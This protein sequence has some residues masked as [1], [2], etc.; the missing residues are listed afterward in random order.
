MGPTSKGRQGMGSG[1]DGTENGK[2]RERKGGEGKER[3]GEERDEREG[4]KRVEV[5]LTFYS[6]HPINLGLWACG[7]PCVNTLVMYLIIMNHNKIYNH[8][9]NQQTMSI[10]S[11]NSH[12][13][14]F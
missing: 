5:L 10:Q 8:N 12:Q 3:R 2:G 14:N 11:C 4:G 6:V 13:H 1:G 7:R 9:H